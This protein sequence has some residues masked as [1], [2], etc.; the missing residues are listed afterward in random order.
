MHPLLSYFCGHTSR[1]S[2]QAFSWAEALGLGPASSPAS[3][4]LITNYCC[5][6]PPVA[7]DLD[8]ALRARALGLSLS[9]LQ[10]ALGPLLCQQ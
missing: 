9:S 2:C 1:T 10:Q 3:G 6:I 4:L 8:H 5:H 7:E